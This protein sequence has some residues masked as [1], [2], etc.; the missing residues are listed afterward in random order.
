MESVKAATVSRHPAHVHF[1]WFTAQ[2][3]DPSSGR[4][5][6]VVLRQSGARYAVPP[7]RSIL[8]V[9]GANDSGVPFSCREG[10][11]AT[12]R[13]GVLAGISDHRDSV[14]SAEERAANDQILICVSC[15]QSEVLELDL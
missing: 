11:C 7:G 5:F 10:L 9:L 12:C 1:E 2:L 14:L 6:T 15:A 4:E 13:T 3:A 8:E